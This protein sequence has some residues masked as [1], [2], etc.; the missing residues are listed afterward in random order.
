M[1]LIPYAVFMRHKSWLLMMFGC[2]LL[3]SAGLAQGGDLVL[4]LRQAV[5]LA[6][7]GNPGLAEIKARA[8][9]LSAVPSQEG[10]LPD[11]SLYFD[12][13]NVPTSS[14]SLRKEDM[15]MMEAGFSQALPFPGKLALKE[16]AA[17]QEALAAADSVGVAYSRLVRD[18]KQAW[19]RL[20]YYDKA[21]Y[22]NG[23]AEKLFQQLIDAAQSKYRVG[24]G[25]QQ[26]VLLAQLELSK[27][28]DEKLELSGMRHSQGIQINALMN[29]SAEEGISLLPEASINTPELTEQDLQQQ[30][31]QSNPRFQQ[32]RKML[33][34]AKTK[35]D[36]AER[37]FYP[38]FNFG[39]GY[40]VRQN[41]P[42]GEA[43]SDFASVRL[44]ITLP[45]Y[46]DQK[47][48]RALDQRHSELLQ[49]QYSQQDEHNKIHAEISVNSS[50]YRHAKERM[51]LFEREII[52]QTQQTVSTLMAGYPLGK[53]SFSDLL[54]AQ[55]LLFQYQ[56][57]YWKSLVET[58]QL[59]AELTNLTGEEASHD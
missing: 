17:E 51:A 13:L 9:A 12:T 24:Q 21:L 34:V 42:N 58:Q 3:S 38:D 45:I 10:A 15:T 57:Q 44:S 25:Q 6:Q 22:L 8:E 55:L 1:Y 47:Q 29:H 20:F 7:A 50:Q 16:K 40:A 11:P 27:L 54:R 46:A 28:K 18:V 30:A 59:L 26:E 5:E 52:P 31:M 36:M 43:R 41:M 4:S 19:W 53:T 33:G 23:E 2:L 48:S 56:N 14:F 49:E 37:D 32:H 35:V 39:A